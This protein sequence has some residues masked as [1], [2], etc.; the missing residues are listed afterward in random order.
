MT[1]F[2]PPSPPPALAARVSP[3]PAAALRSVPIPKSVISVSTPAAPAAGAGTPP[4]PGAPPKRREWVRPREPILRFT[5]TAWAK[6]LFF[7]HYGETEI[8]GFG[9][10]D[11]ADLLRILDFQTVRQTVTSVTVA[12]D[13]TAIADFYDEQVDR[14]RKPQEFS[15]CWL[16]THPGVSP[17][18]SLV[19]EECF[20][21]VFGTCD[22]AVMFILARGGK[23][24]AR[25]RF[26][27]GPGG[28][29]LIPVQVDYTQEFAGSDG[30]A[31][32]QEYLENVQPD[33]LETLLAERHAK[34]PRAAVA[35]ETVAPSEA[36][37]EIDLDEPLDRWWESWGEV[38]I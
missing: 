34:E 1:T 31:W 36:L 8:G 7:C 38:P 15:R 27:A 6:L 35:G 11:P 23:T 28:S 9:I 24:Y 16:H 3:P 22:W 37:P 17:T 13:D 21:R 14:G 18:P 32:E 4:E 30:L 5:P 29:L 12:F 19:D 20:T 10:S 33:T 25:L 26:N 2:L